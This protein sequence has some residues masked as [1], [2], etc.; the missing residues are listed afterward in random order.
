VSAAR[1]KRCVRMLAV[2]REEHKSSGC[3]RMV[4]WKGSLEVVFPTPLL[5]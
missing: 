3:H 4:R 2:S 5:M 1:K